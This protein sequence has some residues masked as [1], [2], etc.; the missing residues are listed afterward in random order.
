MTDEYED[1]GPVVN[2][3]GTPTSFTLGMFGQDVLEEDEDL[4]DASEE[5]EDDYVEFHRILTE[6]Q[7][8]FNGAF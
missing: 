4:L 8:E 1:F 6:G 3:D 7:P 2:D 5:D